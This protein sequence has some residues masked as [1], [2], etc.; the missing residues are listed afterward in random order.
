MKE[1]IIPGKPVAKQANKINSKDKHPRQY[2]S[3][4]KDEKRFEA[5]IAEQCKGHKPYSG[6]LRVI[7][8]FVVARPKSHFGTGKNSHILKK[9]A[10]VH[11]IVKKNDFDNMLKFVNDRCSGLVWVDDCQIIE[12]SGSKRYCY[13]NEEPKTVLRVYEL[14]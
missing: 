4:A 1:I 11:W 6:A 8:E 14:A 12:F 9:T 3:Q 5:I 7:Y 13:H 10:P 2:S